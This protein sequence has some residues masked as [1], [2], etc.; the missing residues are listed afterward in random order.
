M[1]T[2]QIIEGIG[3]DLKIGHIIVIRLWGMEA[4]ACRRMQNSVLL[5]MRMFLIILL[6]RL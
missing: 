6:V 4:I 3:F 2:R 5:A 1:D